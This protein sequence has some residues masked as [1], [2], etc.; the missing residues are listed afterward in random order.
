MPSRSGSRL[1]SSIAVA[2]SALLALTYL[3]PVVTVR[4][5]VNCSGFTGE[6]D[7]TDPPGQHNYGVKATIEKRV[8]ALCGA[9]WSDSSIW[10]MTTGGCDEEY[11]QAG[12]GRHNGQADVFP[13]AQ[14]D[15][16]VGT[17]FVD[18]QVAQAVPAGSKVYY[19]KYNFSTGNI[20]ATYDGTTLLSVN[21]DTSWCT[22]RGSQYEA[23]THDFGDDVPGTAANKADVDNMLVITGRAGNWVAPQG[24]TVSSTSNRYDVDWAV[25]QTHMRVWTK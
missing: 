11:I 16:G 15:L 22:G 3:G 12:Y 2:L 13:F 18:K 6:F 19:T 20:S 10:V 21:V 7:G 4:A 23:E 17:P 5:A 24:L 25:N 9:Q 8:P 14:Y 1:L